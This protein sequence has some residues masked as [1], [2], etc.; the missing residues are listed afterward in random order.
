MS[1]SFLRS[2]HSADGALFRF[3]SNGGLAA[4]E[5][6]TLELATVRLGPHRRGRRPDALSQRLLLARRLLQWDVHVRCHVEN[7]PNVAGHCGP[8]GWLADDLGR[9]EPRPAAARS[10]PRA[11]CTMPEPRC[12]RHRCEAAFAG[13]DCSSKR[14]PND[15]G[16]ESNGLCM[17]DGVCECHDGFGPRTPGGVNDCLGR[18]C[19][20]T[21]GLHGTCDSG[22]GECACEPGWTGRACA[23]QGCPSMCSGHGVC[24]TSAAGATCQ[25]DAGY[26]GADCATQGLGLGFR[27]RVWR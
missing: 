10:L 2:V 27:V 4:R 25:C 22:T 16:G 5:A 13:L 17:A 11:S 15:C 6:C 12:F 21:C 1:A 18:L 8:G 24:N 26:S 20:T 23:E 7:R 14:C 19:A 3:D 9:P